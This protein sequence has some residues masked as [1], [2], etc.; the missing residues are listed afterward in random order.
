M[1]GSRTQNPKVPQDNNSTPT[2]PRVKPFDAPSAELG[3]VGSGKSELAVQRVF[4]VVGSALLGYAGILP[5][6]EECMS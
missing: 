3:Y 1:H 5:R 4:D 6:R 2:Q